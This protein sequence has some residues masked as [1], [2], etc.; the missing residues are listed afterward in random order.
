MRI[1]KHGSYAVIDTGVGIFTA[2]ISATDRETPFS[3]VQPYFSGSNLNPILI[4]EHQVLPLGAQ[5]SLPEDLRNILDE[6]HVTPEL[7]N[8]KVQLL[9]GQGPETYQ[10]EYK[11]GKRSRKWVLDREVKSYLKA[12]EHEEYLLKSAVEYVHMNGHFTKVFRNRAPRTGGKGMITHLEHVS[13]MNARLAWPGANNIPVTQIIEGDF[14]QYWNNGL[15][16]YP[17][18]NQR[19]PFANPVTMFYSS[20]YSFAMDHGY[21]RPSIYGL[22]NWI[23][24]G[25]SLPILLMNY[26]INSAAIRYHITSPA[27]YWEQKKDQLKKNC[28]LTD[29]LYTDKLYEDL[30]DEIYLK[31]AEGLIGIEKAGKMVT[32]ETVYDELSQKYVGWEVATIDQKVKNY[33]DAQLSIAKRADFEI[34]AGVGLHPALSNMSADGNLPSGSEQLYAFKMY[35][36]TGVDIAEGIVCKVLNQA[37]AVNFPDK[38]IKIGF[39]HDTVLTEEATKPTDRVKNN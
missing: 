15:R 25:S 10:L 33:I 5:N 17:V 37:L 13:S 34:T 16:K 35:L 21:A 9:L 3:G 22:F 38:D 4:G 36:Q 23:K 14:V 31:F 1:Y 29:T 30:K 19:D 12:W 24:L 7:L 27:L 18:F 6:N 28:E 26:N 32:T 20:L 11:D 2:E 8:K 39:Y